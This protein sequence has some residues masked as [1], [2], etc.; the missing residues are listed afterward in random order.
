MAWFS[1]PLTHSVSVAFLPSWKEYNSPSE[2]GVN[3]NRHS[4]VGYSGLWVA[5]PTSFHHLS[6]ISHPRSSL[7]TASRLPKLWKIMMCAQFVLFRVPTGHRDTVWHCKTNQPFRFSADEAI[8]PVK[9]SHSYT[10]LTEMRANRKPSEENNCLKPQSTGTNTL[11]IPPFAPTC[12]IA[13]TRKVQINTTYWWERAARTAFSFKTAYVA[14]HNSDWHRCSWHLR[15]RGKKQV[16]FVLSTP[17]W[18]QYTNK[19]SPGA[20]TAPSRR[21]GHFYFILDTR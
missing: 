21:Q 19:H 12:V 2:N 5:L 13:A 6:L 8:S 1:A 9:S 10:H 20:H 17:V 3:N 4:S 14:Q 15:E 16:H 7:K 18:I 11:Y